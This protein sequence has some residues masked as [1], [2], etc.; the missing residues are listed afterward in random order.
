M[1]RPSGGQ[2]P[3]GLSAAQGLATL[4]A[5]LVFLIIINKWCY[6]LTWS[7]K[8]WHSP[9]VGRSAA[10]WRSRRKPLWDEMARLRANIF[11]WLLLNQC[12]VLLV[13]LISIYL[14][15]PILS[16]AW[17]MATQKVVTVFR[18]IDPCLITSGNPHE[19]VTRYGRMCGV[20]SRHGPKRRASCRCIRHVRINI[21][22][23]LIFGV[24]TSTRD[25]WI[26]WFYLVTNVVD[27]QWS[28]II[29]LTLTIEKWTQ[30]H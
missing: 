15:I 3:A 13:L 10:W 16:E 20:H 19:I 2:P 14:D 23:L 28:G 25:H 5:Y 4:R 30:Y 12:W 7:A 9:A 22:T 27:L 6:F 21:F 24:M 29:K 11:E 1:I 8:P 17:V 18:Q 26:T